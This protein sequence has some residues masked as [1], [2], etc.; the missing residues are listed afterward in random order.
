MIDKENWERLDNYHI[1][2]FEEINS[3]FQKF[4]GNEV[5]E[6]ILLK[7]GLRNTNYKVMVKNQ[8]KNFLLRIY[9]EDD[10]CENEA[11]Q[12]NTVRKNVP[13]P[14]V[15]YSDTSKEDFD[16]EYMIQSWENGILMK[17][18]L[19]DKQIN[20][21]KKLSILSQTGEILANI[22]K[23]KCERR[24]IDEINYEFI[25]KSL[26]ESEIIKSRL[27]QEVII[28]INNYLHNNHMILSELPKKVSI[29]HADFNMSNILV[30][31]IKN[32][33]EI[34]AILDWEFS[35]CELNLFDIANFCRY[36]KNLSNP[37]IEVFISSY[38]SNGGHLPNNWK[39][40]I[41]YLDLVA[42]FQMLSTEKVGKN[43]QNAIKE[44]ISDTIS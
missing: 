31:P 22:H 3:V 42:L 33:F 26:L 28:K 1:L 34:S 2:S 36:S 37:L 10:M 25:L 4:L 15:I 32:T 40:I 35:F 12:L 41:R 43:T 5:R 27:N 24:K 16:F 14:Q 11:K 44:L 29:I 23:Y 8:F 39:K 20:S 13:V 9:L 30:A 7:N 21:K 18:F 19:I 6:F 38:I 17:D